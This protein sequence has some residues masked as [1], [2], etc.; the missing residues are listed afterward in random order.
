MGEPLDPR[1]LD[2]LALIALTP[3]KDG[4]MNTTLLASVL[5]VQNQEERMMDERATQNT[6]GLIGE[7]QARA[8]EAK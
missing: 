2:N 5:G 3:N 4:N 7:A 8:L 1:E 6:R